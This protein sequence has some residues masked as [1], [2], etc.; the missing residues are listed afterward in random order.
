M[1]GRR[2]GVRRLTVHF[3]SNPPAEGNPMKTR[4]FIALLA[5][6]PA[7]GMAEAESKGLSVAARVSTL[8]AGL[9]FKYPLH[10]KFNARLVVNQYDKSADETR[11]GNR[12]EGDL[13]LST[14]GLIG[15]WHPTGG[16]FRLS[17]GVI[18]NG[19]ELNARTAGNNFEFG[20]RRYAGNASAIAEFDSLAPYIGL[21]WSSQKPKGWSF[22]IE[23]GALF[24]GDV[25]LSG[26]GTA[27][28]GG[29]AC[30]FSVND[31][32]VA[33]VAAGARCPAAAL[34]NVAV[35]DFIDD[36]ET[37]H[38]ELEDDLGALEV[39]PVIAIGIQYRF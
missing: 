8:G 11:K 35:A 19:N 38:A 29:L 3:N 32:G 27:T 22:D 9:E 23:V 14:Y 4:L 37:E 28:G 26:R 7:A 1:T 12:Y 18:A 6:L 25:M 13:E 21:G 31:N 16:G 33:S 10:Q 5:F 34:G 24:Q 39:Y 36:V 20:G 2:R 15:D 17:A 30:N